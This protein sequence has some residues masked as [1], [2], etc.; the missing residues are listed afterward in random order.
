LSFSLFLDDIKQAILNRSNG[1]RPIT[2]V[3]YSFGARVIYSCLRE[4]A[5]HTGELS[6]DDF[7]LE[8]DNFHRNMEKPA[9]N[10]GSNT[11][12]TTEPMNEGKKETDL[13]NNQESG[14][15]KQEQQASSSK[16]ASSKKPVSSFFTS[17]SKKSTGAPTENSEVPKLTKLELKSVI[18]DVV[19]LGAP[20]S[21]KS[22]A[23]KAIRSIVAGR[24][25]NGYSESD[26]VLGLI[27]R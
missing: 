14:S 16:P 22:R 20:V 23:W 15:A 6:T 21:S 7:D 5:L 11:A 8:E 18:Q 1:T 26:L 27:Y 10:D 9:E 24:V 17:A 25:I 4:L 13:D 3:G 12:A 2:L 19:L